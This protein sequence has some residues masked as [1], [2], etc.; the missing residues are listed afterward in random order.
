MTMKVLKSAGGAVFGPFAQ[1]TEESARY[2]CDGVIYPRAVVGASIIQDWVAPPAAPA[3][4]PATIT[5]LQLTLG[6]VAAGLITPTEGEAMASGIGIPANINTAISTLPIAAQTEARIRFKG[7][8]QV[9]RANPLI[10]AVGMIAAEKTPA[11]MD[12]H[13]IA[14]SVL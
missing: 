4:A 3:P 14:W 9:D 8:T 7:M 2:L 11:Q 5:K 13:F 6:L 1:I 12:Q 10:D